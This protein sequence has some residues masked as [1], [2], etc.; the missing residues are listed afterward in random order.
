MTSEAFCAPRDSTTQYAA[1]SARSVHQRQAYRRGQPWA[2]VFERQHTTMGAGDRRNNRK[3][4]PTSLSRPTRIQSDKALSG[5]AAV[6]D[7]NAGTG[8][9]NLHLRF[10]HSAT[11]R[12][13]D[14]TLSRRVFQGVVN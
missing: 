3:A 14:R 4:K 13:T 1:L 12:N 8:I 7:W 5:P 11:S 2:V 6:I 9:G 10:S